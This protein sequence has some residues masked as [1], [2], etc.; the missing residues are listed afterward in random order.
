MVAGPPC[1]EKAVALDGRRDIV[2]ALIHS[3]ALAVDLAGGAHPT[4]GFRER[5]DF[6]PGGP[7]P[8]GPW[9][10]RSSAS[11]DPPPAGASKYRGVLDPPH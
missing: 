5:T 3:R 2:A 11:N 8:A 9:P 10:R 1:Q 7:R 6:R 4:V